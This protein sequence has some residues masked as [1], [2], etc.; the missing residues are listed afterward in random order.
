MGRR[1]WLLYLSRRLV[2]CSSH[3][4]VWRSALHTLNQ[5]HFQGELRDGLQAPP[6]F[7]GSFVEQANGL[8]E[9]FHWYSLGQRFHLGRLLGGEIEQTCTGS[10]VDQEQAT[11]VFDN[12]AP[13]LTR[14]CTVGHDAVDHIQPASYITIDQVGHQ[15]AGLFTRDGAQHHLHQLQRDLLIIA[16][17]LIQQADGITHGAGSLS[18]NELQRLWSYAHTLLLGDVSQLIDDHLQGQAPEV[19][20]LATRGD[21][22]RD[23][24]RIGGDKGKDNV[25]RRLFQCFE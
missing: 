20:P 14:V 13:K 11:Q 12:L 2:R 17:Q 10:L 25:W 7:R 3:R 5:R 21:G 8:Q 15:F 4:T 23:F 9:Q 1:L 18:R 19:K 6:Q 22:R 24:V 16:G